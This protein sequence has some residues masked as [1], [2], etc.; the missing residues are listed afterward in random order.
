[1]GVKAR[2]NGDEAQ[3]ERIHRWLR[4]GKGRGRGKVATNRKMRKGRSGMVSNDSGES[5][6]WY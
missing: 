6:T 2:N 3:V 5:S 1:M 4:E